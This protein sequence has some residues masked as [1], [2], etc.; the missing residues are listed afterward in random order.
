[1]RRITKKPTHG[2]VVPLVHHLRHPPARHL[3][4][5]A[6]P[7][8]RQASAVLAQP[9]AHSSVAPFA[10]VGAPPASLRILSR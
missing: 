1:M 3:P 8:L 5:V 7:H 9:P 2:D 6:Y 4:A 10:L